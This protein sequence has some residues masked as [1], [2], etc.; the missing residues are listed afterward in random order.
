MGEGDPVHISRHGPVMV[1]LP[2]RLLRTQAKLRDG[3]SILRQGI[4]PV[5]ILIQFGKPQIGA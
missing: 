4:G 2:E 3:A 5:P 1:R